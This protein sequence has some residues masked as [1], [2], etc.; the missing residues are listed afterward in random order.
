MVPIFSTPSNDFYMERFQLSKMV[1]IIDLLICLAFVILTGS[2]RFCIQKEVQN[3]EAK[4]QLLTEFSIEIKNL[5][6]V[7]VY[8]TLA[9]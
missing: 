5:P 8:G 4:E 1:I 6:I 9:N 2:L 7:E 3:V